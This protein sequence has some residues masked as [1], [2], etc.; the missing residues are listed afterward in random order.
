MNEIVIKENIIQN[1]IYE[2]R[3]VQVMLD[4]D[5]AKL[6]K[7]ANGTKSIN[8][9]VKRHINRFPERYMFQL[10]EEEYNVLR[11]QFETANNMSRTLP[12][13]FTEEGVAMLSAILHTPV[14]TKVSI[15]IMDAFVSMRHLISNNLSEQNNI[16]NM[17]IKHDND[18]KILQDTFNKFI[19]P[20]EKNKIFYDGQ[21]YDAYS[22]LLDILDKSKKEIII[23]DNYADKKL[24]DLLSKTNKK[25]KVYSKNMTE[26]LIK[27]YSKQYS[28]A[29]IISSD[30]FHD[31]FVIIDKSILYNVGASFKDLGNKCFSINKIE[32]ETIIDSIIDRLK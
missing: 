29:E 22:L 19:K 9:A 23:I 11:F 3:G 21:V 32:D 8:L 26:E 2:I 24:L 16:N 5:L 7:C 28:N 12:Y 30:I 31:R 17:V 25:V 15:N 20:E 14:A 27:K 18:I 6:Y 4:S 13:V 10:T 1:M